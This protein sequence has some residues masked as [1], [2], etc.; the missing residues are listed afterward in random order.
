MKTF[1]PSLKSEEELQRV[2]LE[3]LKWTVK[4]AYEGS[5]FYRKK[6]E[7]TGGRPGAIRSLEDIQKLPFTTADDLNICGSGRVRGSA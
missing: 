7:E 4:H 5:P 2:Q 1:M 6:L 3:G